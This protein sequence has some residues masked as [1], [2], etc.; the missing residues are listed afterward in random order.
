MP[1]TAARFAPGERGRC[2]QAPREVQTR[3]LRTA[4]IGGGTQAYNKSGIVMLGFVGDPE[5]G[6]YD[7]PVVG[8]GVPEDDW[9]FHKETFGQLAG[10]MTMNHRARRLTLRRGCYAGHRD[11]LLDP[12]TGSG[13]RALAALVKSADIVIG[14]SRPRVLAG[15]G[16]DGEAAA[17]RGTVW[18]SITAAGR[19]SARVALGD[20]VRAGAGL[21]A[22]DEQRRPVFCGDAPTS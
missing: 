20:D 4:Q 18:I 3:S 2:P 21:V 13:R 11:V 22:W 5:A 15:F 7:H 8:T 14:A 1:A 12:S 19:N 10:G 16:L 6:L 9:L 17:D